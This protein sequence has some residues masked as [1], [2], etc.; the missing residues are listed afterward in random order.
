MTNLG[1]NIQSVCGTAQACRPTAAGG[2]AWAIS[3]PPPATPQRPMRPGIGIGALSGRARSMFASLVAI[4]LILPAYY[5]LIWTAFSTSLSDHF[6]VL[7]HESVEKS[8]SLFVRF[9]I[10]EMRD[11]LGRSVGLPFSPIHPFLPSAAPPCRPHSSSRPSGPRSLTYHRD[12][13]LV[14]CTGSSNG[15]ATTA[16]RR[17]YEGRRKFDLRDKNV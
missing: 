13:D 7:S 4:F 15:L 9:D 5:I 8:T 10:Q 6:V 16:R 3:A 11:L 17:A 14:E 12:A 1:A 2:R